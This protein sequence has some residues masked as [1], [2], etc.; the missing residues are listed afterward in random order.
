MAAPV[1]RPAPAALDP[2]AA[3]GIPFSGPLTSTG[4]PSRSA[5]TQ[6]LWQLHGHQPPPKRVRGMHVHAD[7]DEAAQAGAGAGSGEVGGLEGDSLAAAVAVCEFSLAV[8]GAHAGTGGAGDTGTVGDLQESDSDNEEEEDRFVESGR[9]AEPA[10]GGGGSSLPSLPL[11]SDPVVATLL[12]DD[13]YGR[14]C[15]PP[16]IRP[17]ILYR[18]KSREGAALG[19][20]EEPLAV[21][22]AA[23]GGGSSADSEGGQ[24]SGSAIKS[25]YLELQSRMRLALQ[26]VPHPGTSSGLPETE[27]SAA[28]RQ[29]L[30]CHLGVAVGCCRYSFPP[31]A[32]QAAPSTWGAWA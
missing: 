23:A 14:I 30:V 32:N 29:R 17:Q 7:G 5:F 13:D 4:A 3:T 20:G 22:G 10:G 21:A 19:A 27:S 6:A 8:D 24:H 1:P 28:A 31:R 15:L 2:F 11:D 18:T 25:R 12:V 26:V 9:D 16:E